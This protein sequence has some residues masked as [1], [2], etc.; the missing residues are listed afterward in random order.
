M[1]N[2]EKAMTG[3]ASIGLLGLALLVAACSGRVNVGFEPVGEAGAPSDSPASGGSGSGT[4]QGNAGDNATGSVAGTGPTQGGS[5]ASGVCGFT[6]DTVAPDA[7]PVLTTAEVLTRLHLFLENDDQIPDGALPPAPTGGWLAG[8]AKEI[9]DSHAA[10]ETAPPGLVRFLERWLAV[11]DP[12]LELESPARWALELAA[13]NA[14]LTTLLAQ[15]TG[16]PHRLGIL[17]EPEFL[18]AFPSISMRGVWMSEQLFCQQVP[19]PPPDT[20][21]EE[22]GPGVTRREQLESGTNMAVCTGCHQ[23]FDPPG[24]SLE[25][26]DELGNYREEEA[27]QPVNAADTLMDPPMSFDDYSE[28]APQLATSCKVGHC[29]ADQLIRDALGQPLSGDDAMT[30]TEAEINRIAGNFANSGYSIRVLVDSI[31]RSPSFLR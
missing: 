26:F 15:P 12:S 24:N 1:S 4:S 14:T 11:P 23:I 18:S 20:L 3:R 29:F 21:I 27:G 25:H 7:R 8:Y 28:L 9:L 30:F 16:E 31:V 17:T 19:A 5:T 2:G 22:P 6:P 13:P 10:A